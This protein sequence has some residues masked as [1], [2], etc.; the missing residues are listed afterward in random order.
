MQNYF[1]LMGKPILPAI[2]MII[3]LCQSVSV[4]II[5]TRHC[6]KSLSGYSILGEW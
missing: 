5:F 6:H 4:P 3:D 2:N 1:S